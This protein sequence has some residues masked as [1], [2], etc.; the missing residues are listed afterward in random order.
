MARLTLSGT[1]VSGLVTGARLYCVLVDRRGSMKNDSGEVPVLVTLTG[2]VTGVPAARMVLAE[3]G[4]PAA[5]AAGELSFIATVNGSESATPETW[6]A[7]TT[8][9]VHVPATGEST[10]SWAPNSGTAVGPLEPVTSSL[11]EAKA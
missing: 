3:S 8:T 4:R 7:K 6:G 5:E 10:W 9:S 11:L 1:V 2:T